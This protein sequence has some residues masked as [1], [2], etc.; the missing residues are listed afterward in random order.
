MTSIRSWH[1]LQ[2]IRNPLTIT[3][4]SASKMECLSCAHLFATLVPDVPLEDEGTLQMLLFGTEVTQPP[5]GDLEQSRVDPLKSIRTLEPSA[6]Y[7]DQRT[8]NRRRIRTKCSLLSFYPFYSS[9]HERND[10][11]ETTTDSS[12]LVTRIHVT[13]KDHHVIGD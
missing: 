11:D 7:G 3:C 9:F 4:T 8:T 10:F 13:A 1:Q 6:K 5:V 12:S 2:S